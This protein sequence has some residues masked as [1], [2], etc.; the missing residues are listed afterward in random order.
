M[1]IVLL[2]FTCVAF[3]PHT[4]SVVGRAN[5][6]SFILRIIKPRLNI[7]NDFPKISDGDQQG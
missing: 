4:N 5:I 3:A 7:L 1:S 2:E 6:S